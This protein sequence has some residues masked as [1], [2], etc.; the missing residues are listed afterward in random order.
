MSKDKL[1]E[2]YHAM[3]NTHSASAVKSGR[4]ATL[5]VIAGQGLTEEVDRL[6]EM[7]MDVLS[8]ITGGEA[9]AGREVTME[10]VIRHLDNAKALI[11]EL[12]A[13]GQ[14]EALAQKIVEE[15]V[16][17][18]GV[19]YDQHNREVMAAEEM[20]QIAKAIQEAI[21]KKVPG[22]KVIH[23]GPEKQWN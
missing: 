5:R 14:D 9:T 18:G 13:L 4:E 3:P 10:D 6:H 19:T 12:N 21:E 7:Y 2:K 11:R 8:I 16:A 15:T 17:D 23:V 20:A 22:A 1:R